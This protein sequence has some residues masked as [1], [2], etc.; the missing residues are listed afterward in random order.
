M[1][2]II[3]IIITS[4]LLSPVALFIYYWSKGLP[5]AGNRKK[6]SRKGPKY[7]LRD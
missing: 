3:S 5:G 1:S 7:I 4:L 6:H 2:H